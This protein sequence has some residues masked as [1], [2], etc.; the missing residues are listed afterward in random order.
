MKTDAKLIEDFTSSVQLL[1]RTIKHIREFSERDLLE[2]LIAREQ[3]TERARKM[4]LMA[5]EIRRSE[6]DGK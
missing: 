6:D 2:R 3:I 4:M 5:D 1:V